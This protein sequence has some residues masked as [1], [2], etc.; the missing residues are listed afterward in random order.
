MDT[1]TYD[2][3]AGLRAAAVLILLPAI[4]HAQQQETG[5]P[6]AQLDGAGGISAIEEI[7]VTGRKRGAELLQD[8]PAAITAIGR[9]TLQ[10]Q[11]IENFEDFAYFVPGLSFS[12]TGPGEKRYVIRGIQSAGQ[13][14]VA[15]YYDEVPIPGVQDASSDSGSQTT[16]LFLYDME[17]IEVFRGPQGTTFGANSQSGLVRFLTVKPNLS[18]VEASVKGNVSHTNEGSEDWFAA[19]MIN[20]P[21]IENELAVRLVPTTGRMS[22]FVDN[23]G[24]GRLDE[25]GDGQP[26]DPG[27]PLINFNWREWTSLRAML[28]WQPI[29]EFTIDAMAWL[30]ERDSGGSD[31]YH[32]FDTI[33]DDSLTQ[34]EK[35]ALSSDQGGRD[36]AP[37]VARFQTGQFISGDLTRTKK[38]DDQ[39][40]Y[41][42]TAEYQL[43]WA[44][45]TAAGS[46]YTRDF[47]FKFDSTWI[48][49]F[50]GA[51]EAGREDLVPAVT[52]QFQ[53]LDQW[54]GEIRLNSTHGGPV[55][56]LFGV[57]ARDRESE[58]QSF[59]PVVEAESGEQFDPGTP[60]TGPSDEPGAGIEGCLPCVFARVSTKDIEEQAVFGELSYAFL[61]DFEATVGLRWF[62]VEQSD[63]GATVFQFALF[64]S[65]IPPALTENAEEDRLIKKFQLSW[66]PTPE[67]TL[68]GVA[69]QG[70]RLGGT[71]NQGIADV[72]DFFEADD[73]WNFEVGAKTQLFGNRV[74]FNTSL[75]YL[76][77]DNLQVA[78]QDPT[79]AFGFVG[80]AGEAE[81][82]GLEAEIFASPI[83]DLNL[84]ANATW[85]P[86]REL[87]EDQVSNEIV[88]PGRA[89]DLIPRIP[90]LQF[91]LTGQYFYDVPNTESWRGSIRGELAYRGSSHTELVT[92]EEGNLN[93]RFQDAF[94]ITN[95]RAGFDNED[96]AANVSLFVENAFDVQGDVFIGV[97]NGQPTF[98][99]TNRPRTIGLE[100][101]KY[102]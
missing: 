29:P 77:W 66:T 96:W 74:V 38:P 1:I 23:F 69:S 35:L 85:L 79:G 21:I 6:D 61:D 19:G 78:G 25:D 18:D 98:K 84:T 37:E 55:Q 27:E 59:V 86:T 14:Q 42:L 34:Q 73:L 68:Y 51:I 99:I 39:Q 10:N 101:S 90:E 22:G 31:R 57:F 8:V 46:Y 100:I 72:P 5:V 30:Q 15:V 16:D 88:A 75:F 47:G 92:F 63:F 52:D 48:I 97:G 54:T 28:R 20:V 81:V 17:R 102:F 40:I 70:F 50:L 71:N 43:P 95:F 83:Q 65:N 36:R 56:W 53:S 3:G 26:D 82:L 9:E 76:L 60:I 2:M 13:Q 67:V 24:L 4:A 45:L 87:T 89:G 41:S 91:S 11:S 64:G 49:L 44:N 94:T 7:I 32:P 93:D 58:F 33:F 80:N 62:R 12:D